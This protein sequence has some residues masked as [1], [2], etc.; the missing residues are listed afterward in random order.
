MVRLSRVWTKTCM[1]SAARPVVSLQGPTLM[2]L[3]VPDI[4]STCGCAPWRASPVAS[5]VPF[6]A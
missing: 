1:P 6:W 5:P 4:V 3:M 2:S